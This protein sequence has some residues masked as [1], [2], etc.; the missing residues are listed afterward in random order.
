MNSIDVKVVLSFLECLVIKKCSTAMISNYGS[1]IK[2]CFVLYDLPYH[3]WI[4]VKLNFFKN[5]CLWPLFSHNI[6]D[7]SR[8]ESISI[9][10]DKLP[11]PEELRVVFL[12]AFFGF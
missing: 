5:P 7:L 2:A 4:T 9:A 3:L 1:G 8:L 12:T 11:C 6:I 10:C